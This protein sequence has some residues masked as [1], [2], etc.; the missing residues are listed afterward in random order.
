[1]K[2]RFF[3]LAVVLAGCMAALSAYA[4]TADGLTYTLSAFATPNPAPDFDTSSATA[5]LTFIFGGLAMLRARR[6][7]S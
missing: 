6:R 7:R 1:M 5:A 3:T 2:A 4:L